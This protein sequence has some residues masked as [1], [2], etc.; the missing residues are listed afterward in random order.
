M[1]G[2]GNNRYQLLDVYDLCEAIYLCATLPQDK[3]NDVFNIG[4]QNFTTMKEDYQIVLDEAG[5]KK[6]ILGFPAFP[7]IWTLRFL[8][9]LH[10]SPLYK[11]I[12]ETA[13][14]DSFVSIDKAKKQLGWMPKYSNKD[15]LFRNYKWYLEHLNDFKNK[16][17]VSHR[18]P[19]KQGIL[20]L[21]KLFF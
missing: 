2:N 11:W 5:F 6:R 17:G 8:E 20:G 15:A 14:E 21:I 13:C 1:I 10:L 9:A 18:V 12:Y 3:V 4:A 19:W 16:S 7:V